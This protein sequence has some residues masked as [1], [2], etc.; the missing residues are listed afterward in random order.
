[1]ARTLFPTYRY[2]NL[3]SF[4]EQEFAIGDPKGFLTRFQGEEGVILD[5]IQKT[6]KLLSYIQLEVDQNQ[7]LGLLTAC[8]NIFISVTIYSYE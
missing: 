8:N 3:E 5:E 4:E 7:P 2:I 1:M 6:P